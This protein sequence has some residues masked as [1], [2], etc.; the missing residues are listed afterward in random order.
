MLKSKIFWIVSCILSFVSF[1]VAFPVL[2]LTF[3]PY[4][5]IAVALYIVI[6]IILSA[7]CCRKSTQS[8]AKK[9]LLFSVLLIPVIALILILISIETGWIYFPG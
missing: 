8:I 5:I 9:R 1:V 2:L 6:V 7:L 3:Y 4:S